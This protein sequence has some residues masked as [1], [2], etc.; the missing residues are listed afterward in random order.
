MKEDVGLV[1]RGFMIF[2]MVMVDVVLAVSVLG[3][4]PLNLNFIL[5]RTVIVQV[6]IRFDAD[7]NELRAA[8]AELIN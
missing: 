7:L 6:R 1:D 5:D 8:L 3:T 2:V 4:H